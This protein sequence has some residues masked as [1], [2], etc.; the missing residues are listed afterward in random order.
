MGV[1]KIFFISL[2][3]MMFL[4]TA[5]NNKAGNDANETAD[6]EELNT[7]GFP[8]VDEP[9]DLKFF[10]GKYPSNSDKYEELLIWKKYAEETNVNV[11]FELHPFDTLSEKK[12]VVL[13]GGDYPD[14]FYSARLSSSELY[15]YGKQGTFIPL[16]DLIDEYAPNL[17]KLMEA[18][19]NLE[20]GLTMPDGNIYS[21]PSYYDPNFLAMLIGTPLW[22][23]EPWLEELNMDEPQTTEE[24]YDYLKAVKETDLNGNGEND[25]IP[26]SGNGISPLLY[27]LKGAWGLGNMGNG[28]PLI[29]L[30]PET[31]ELRF[32][33]TDP[34]YKEVLEYVHTLYS[35][36]LIDKEIFEI[37]SGQLNAK[38]AE[39]LLGSVIVPNP[40]SVMDKDGFIGLSA[41]KGPHGDQ[42]YSQLKT[43]IVHV[44]AFAITDKNEHP[45]ATVR[46]MD[47]FFSDEGATFYF[48]GVEGE[49]YEKK[50]EKE[51]EYVE[52]ITDNPDGLTYA[53]AIEKYFSWNGG[54]YPGYVQEWYFKGSESHPNALEAAEKARDY[55]GET[56][57][58]FNYTEEEINFK[59]SVGEDITQYISEKEA[60]FITG[61]TP[62][63]EWDSFVEQIE[64][65]GKDRLMEIENDAF[66]RYNE[67]K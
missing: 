21:F 30:D 67:G 36:G 46:W 17:K 53:Q 50:G 59:S 10:T 52:E 12:G 15:K 66:E 45:A 57:N 65:M 22:V 34:K 55:I 19:P 16:N 61:R 29:D 44:G 43:P 47:H 31:D 38:G 13:A 20:K 5:C 41:L 39:G 25:E 11:E 35:E 23:Y 6:N 8:I 58:A 27:Q 33:R 9:I 63:S 24:F 26:Y 48:M 18:D 28:H 42:I 4:L 64:K 1:R 54:S 56:Y 3:I 51:L 49:T 2:V 37:E 62:F 32:Y 40:S 7:E 14:A 60:E